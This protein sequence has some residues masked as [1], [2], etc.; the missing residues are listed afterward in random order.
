MLHGIGWSAVE[1]WGIRLM[2]LVVF[3]ILLRTIDASEFGLASF[4]TAITSMLLVF[5][6]AGFA[7]ALIQKRELGGDDATTAFWTS[8]A[9]AVVIYGLIFFTAPLIAS[10]MEMEQLSAMLRVLGLSLFAS[11]MSSVPA[12][13]LERDMNFK[14]LG[15]RSIF[16]TVVGAAI[17]V[18]MALFGMGVWALI[19]QM[20]AT[21]VAGTIALWF[22]TSWRP[23]F[24]YSVPALR[25]LMSFGVSVLGLEILNRTQQN[26]DK[27]LVNV[28]LGP[29][30]GGIY[31]VAQRAMKLVSE[32][33]SSVISKI[34]L[35][36]FSKLQDDRE[37]LNRAFLQLTFAAG[38]IAIPVLGIIAALGDI[39]MPYM[40]G[41]GEWERAVPIMQILAV[42]MSMAAI[43]RF[44]KQTLLAVGRPARA[45]ALGLIENIVG[46]ALLMIAAPFG[47][48]ALAVG[49]ALRIILTW[50]YRIYLLKKYASI[51]I[52]PYILN[53]VMLAA[54]FIVPLGLLFLC[55]YTPWRQATPAFWTF[56]VP[57][58]IMMLLS[59][60]GTLWLVCGRRNRAAI[61]R[62]LKLGRRGKRS[63]T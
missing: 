14:S 51:Q 25:K 1:K 42:S 57:M 16:G 17:A 9:I 43:C 53:T 38:G 58:S 50:P 23:T 60:Y 26:I 47:L 4:T 11:A 27:V 44:D 34:A 10:W 30:A 12:A 46:V 32:L 37:R 13:L 52:V 55:T 5:V 59:Y 8:I 49:R 31:F 22:S 36:T 35:T 6:D 15:L 19:V 20:L 33:V 21:L 61:R 45:F 2:S 54:A 18:P 39:I 62:T 3:V 63:A 29:E 56:A 24:R 41:A 28:L 48:I 7:K 40:S